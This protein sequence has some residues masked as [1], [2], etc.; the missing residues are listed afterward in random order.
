MAK[1]VI[2]GN[3][4]ERSTHTFGRPGCPSSTTMPGQR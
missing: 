4:P 3:V 2:R 1:S